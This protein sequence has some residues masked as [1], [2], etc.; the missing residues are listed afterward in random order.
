[1]MRHHGRAK[2]NTSSDRRRVDANQVVDENFIAGV[3][4]TSK[5]K[6]KA[7]F[8]V[9]DIRRIRSLLGK[10]QPEIAIVDLETATTQEMQGSLSMSVLLVESSWKGFHKG[11]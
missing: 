6:W 10:G 7:P 3:M 11:L 1:M 9:G 2:L 8:L 4:T 5:M